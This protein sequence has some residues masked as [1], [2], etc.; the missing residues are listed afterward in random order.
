MNGLTE[1]LV[2]LHPHL[3]GAVKMVVGAVIAYIAIFHTEIY[4]SAFTSGVEAFADRIVE[5][6][7]AAS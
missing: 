3:R 6:L 5:G 7:V 1:A 4:I 2:T